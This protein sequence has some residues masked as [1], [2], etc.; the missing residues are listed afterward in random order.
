MKALSYILVFIISL[1]FVDAQTTNKIFPNFKKSNIQMS[2][3]GGLITYVTFSNSINGPFTSPA[4]IATTDSL[5]TKLD[6][7]PQGTVQIQ[8]WLDVNENGI[9][10][11]G[12]FPVG[13]ENFTDNA[14]NDLDPTPGVIIGFIETGGQMSSMQVIAIANEGLTSATG[15]VVFNNPPAT[16]SLSGVIYS[17]AGGVVPGAWVW[18]ID[19]M[20]QIGDVA[21]HT[22]S[23]FIP[24][25][26]GN[27]SIHIEDMSG[28]HSSFDTSITIAGNTI[29]NFYLKPLTSYIRGYVRDE[30]SN[31]IANVRLYRE[32]SSG[33]GEVLTDQNGEYKMM[34]PAGSSRI[35][36]NSDDLLPTY[37]SPN[38]HSYTIGENDSIVNNSI[39]NFTCYR[40][41]ST[42]TGAVRVNGNLPTKSYLIGGWADYIQSYSQ[43]ISN[44]TTGNYTLPVYSSTFP[45]TFYGVNLG[46]WDRDYPFPPGAYVD[47]SYGGLLPGASNINFNL[48]SAETSFVEPFLGNWNP[49][50]YNM[51][52]NYIY[53]QPWGPNGM[54]LC[55]NDRLNIIASS[56]SGT[57]GLGVISKKPFQLINREYRV[58]IDHT[59]LGPNNTAHILLSNRHIWQL[60]SNNDNWL[61]LSY[62]KQS[63]TGGWKLQQSIDQ[64]ISTLWQSPDLTGG[65]I[66]FQFNNDASILTLKIDGVVKY[67][68]SWGQHFS[69]AYIHLFQFND[70]PNT[71]TPVYFDELFVGAVGSTGVREIGGELPQEFNLEQNY[72]NP[73]NPATTINFQLPISSTVSLK[74]YNVLG[75]GVADLL[76]GELNAG[77]YEIAFDASKLSSGIYYYRLTAVDSKTGQLLMNTSRKAI[78]L[79]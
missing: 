6:V 5:F 31:P 12:D 9:T 74:V 60:P 16:F 64:N 53:N 73:F 55:I 11:A 57:S 42:I 17:T 68:G 45:Q 21:D 44:P 59:Q 7:T 19:G 47:T 25:E 36:L 52:I 30:L 24:L 13:S 2:K 51:W 14:I 15:I 23:Y 75:Q 77:K 63:G 20:N 10:D 26:A 70:Y 69:I 33:M 3:T 65:H 41:N 76:N 50:S 67:S 56:Q 48:V 1:Q 39:S 4:T 28:A 38:S 37:M 72:P 58:Y 22:G 79:K 32:N 27:Y 18:A 43:A 46:D 61:Q 34:V 66:L 71:P 8:Y 40:T 54:V 62:S 29:Q 49:P 35:G 78:L